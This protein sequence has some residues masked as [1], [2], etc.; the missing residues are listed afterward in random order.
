MEL[1]EKGVYDFTIHSDLD[2]NRITPY[3]IHGICIEVSENYVHVMELP[4]YELKYLNGD[5]MKHYTPAG[6][7]YKSESE[8]SEE[9]EE[10]EEIDL[11]TELEELGETYGVTIKLNGKKKHDY[12]AL[13]E[14]YTKINT[15]FNKTKGIPRPEDSHA[16]DLITKYLKGLGVNWKE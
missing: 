7:K 12:E 3:H 11:K 10:S 4:T 9:S 6:E 13:Q 8:K 15:N 5:D 14:L 1:Q 2:G 16:L